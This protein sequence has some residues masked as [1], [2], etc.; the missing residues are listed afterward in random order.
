VTL[1][2]P[3]LE[4]YLVNADAQRWRVHDVAFGRPPAAP[5][6]TKVLPLGD[7]RAT[8]RIFVHQDGTK[9]IAHLLPSP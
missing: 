2:F 6:Y 7:P 3:R 8:T 1:P 4:L 5:H 9:R